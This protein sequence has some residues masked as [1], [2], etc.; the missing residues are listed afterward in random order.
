MRCDRSSLEV[1]LLA[2]MGSANRLIT[3]SLIS[4]FLEITSKRFETADRT[5]QR[6]SPNRCPHEYQ[7]H[8]QRWICGPRAKWTSCEILHSSLRGIS[9]TSVS[10]TAF[11]DYHKGQAHC[12]RRALSESSVPDD[13]ILISHV[14]SRCLGR[15]QLHPSSLD[16]ALTG[17]L[18]ASKPPSRFQNR[19]TNEA[20]IGLASTIA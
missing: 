5:Q 18:W 3:Y 7:K 1:R 14:Q 8:L 16:G 19:C 9:D 12:K 15:W 4:G 11:P 2:L 10:P 17:V 6:A 20:S 13:S